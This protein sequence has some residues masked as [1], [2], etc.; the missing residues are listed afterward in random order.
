MA[1]PHTCHP[2]TRAEVNHASSLYGEVPPSVAFT[3]YNQWASA[4]GY[5]PRTQRALEEKMFKIGA[6]CRCRDSWQYM[7]AKEIGGLLGIGVARLYS[8]RDRIGFPLRQSPWKYGRNW[9][10]ERDEL[11]RYL[12]LRPHLLMGRPA[13]GINWLLDDWSTAC[14]LAELPPYRRSNLRHYA[15]GLRF[16]SL[17]DLHAYFSLI[18]Q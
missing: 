8:W 15:G 4:N 13:A 6:S 1:R 14:K 9:Y 17:K 7:T 5:P 3:D 16:N 10:A 11:V 12:R 2:W 18:P